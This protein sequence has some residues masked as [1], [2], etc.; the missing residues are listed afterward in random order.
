MSVQW[1]SPLQ[2]FYSDLL[3]LQGNV[4]EKE[5]QRRPVELY[6][7]SVLKRQGY[8][9]GKLNPTLN[10]CGR[11]LVN[12]YVLELMSCGYDAHD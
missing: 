2:K 10:D 6:M 1:R 4:S 3:C 5:L 12:M 11:L 9:E 7:C 8:G